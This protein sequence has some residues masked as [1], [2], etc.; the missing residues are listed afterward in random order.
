LFSKKYR[1]SFEKERKKIGIKKFFD[2]LLLINNL[3]PDFGVYIITYAFQ[4]RPVKQ[5][6]LYIIYTPSDLIENFKQR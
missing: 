5:F 3:L 1:A 2:G 6:K 4:G